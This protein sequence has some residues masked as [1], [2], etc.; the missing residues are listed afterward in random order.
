MSIGVA[1][2]G[3]GAVAAGI[4]GIL[5]PAA[6]RFTALLAL[7]AGAGVGVVTLALG[8]ENAGNE[9]DVF[10]VGAA[11]GLATVATTLT[12]AWRRAAA[13]R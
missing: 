8:V 11:L 3:V 12:A 6:H 5:L 2:V 1:L 9:E 4:V 10:L 13:D 7:V